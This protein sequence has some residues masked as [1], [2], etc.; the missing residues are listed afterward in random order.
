MKEAMLTSSQRAWDNS[1]ADTIGS[2]RQVLFSYVLL[3]GLSGNLADWKNDEKL[4]LPVRLFLLLVKN[5]MRKRTK[6]KVNKI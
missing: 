6:M 3:L 4:T 5:K 2:Q 1:Q